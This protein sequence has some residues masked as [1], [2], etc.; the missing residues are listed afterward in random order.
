[1]RR[2]SRRKRA[3]SAVSIRVGVPSRRE[4]RWSRLPSPGRRGCEHGRVLTYSCV[5]RQVLAVLISKP[6]IEAAELSLCGVLSC[7]LDS[8]W[9]QQAA[10]PG[11]V[12][13]AG[14]VPPD[15]EGWA[16]H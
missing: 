15:V 9:F 10:Y 11:A 4:G 1:M 3:L 2:C 5:S 8:C 13:K 7:L 14:L 16:S 12:P 6:R